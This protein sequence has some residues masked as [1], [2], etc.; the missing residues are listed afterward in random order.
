MYR[1]HVVGCSPRSGTTLMTEIMYN[2]FDIDVYSGKEQRI[3]TWPP[4]NGNV[5][6]T[7]SPKDIVV[8]KDLIEKV[9]NLYV[10]YM[11]RDPR[12][13]IV[14]K[15]PWDKDR[16]WSSLKFWKLFTPFGK[17]LKD[18]PRFITVRYEDL[19]S[20]P[21]RVN[22]LIRKKMPF[23]NQKESFSNF[24]LKAQPTD[25]A[26]NALGG[27]RPVSEGSIGNWRNHK[28]RVA[29]QI[30]KHGPITADLIEY[31]YEVDPGWEKEL[32][33]VAPD[34]K[35]SHPSV[36]DSPEFISKKQRKNKWR[37]LEMYISHSNWWLKLKSI[38]AGQVARREGAAVQ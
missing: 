16:Y 14:S 34:L 17:A 1:I 22:D 26:S 23:L 25:F 37:A 21:D 32:A 13:V 15:H 24:H 31:G 35:E 28:E 33:N 36:F 27:L 7:K 19:V 12:D 8:V 11:L 20:D 30:H 18:H 6:L 9:K 2:C 29:G 5:F 38:F 10:I 3:A 4:R